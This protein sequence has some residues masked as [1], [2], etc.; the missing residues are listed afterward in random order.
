MR[1]AAHGVVGHATD[2]LLGLGERQARGA[3]DG[4]PCERVAPLIHQ[5]PDAPQEPDAPLEA[6]V[7]PLDFVL[8]RRDEHHVE[9]QGVGAVAPDHVV[10][11][12]DVA[13][14]LRHDVAVLQH[15][16]LRQQARERFVVLDQPEVAEDAAEEPR[17]DQVQDGVFD[18]A[19]VEVHRGPVL[20]RRGRERLLV[21]VRVGVPVEVPGRVDERVHRVRLAPSRTA[22]RRAADVHPLGDLGQRRIAAP[23]ELGDLREHNRKLVVRHRDDAAPIADDHRNR[24]APVPLARDPPVLQAE[25]HRLRPDPAHL[26]GVRHRLG[27]RRSTTARRT[28]PNP[29]RDQARRTPRPSCPPRAPSRPRLPAESRP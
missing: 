6:R 19:A 23:G 10:G 20:H 4:P 17:V 28:R 3:G 24:R 12:D 8:R 15:H 21:V 18:A 27:S 26:R 29:R 25:L 13:L 7:G 1:H 2:P 11:I 22:A 16:P 5:P 9:A 14:R